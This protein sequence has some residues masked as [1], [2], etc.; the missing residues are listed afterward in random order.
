LGVWA[1]VDATYYTGGRTTID[2][3]RGERQENLRFGVT[4][5][6][7]IDRRNSVKLYGSTGAIAR[8]GGDFDMVGI[9]WQYRWGGGL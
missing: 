8:T 5:A 4:V 1:A 9:A 2:G 3:E 6:I 7:P